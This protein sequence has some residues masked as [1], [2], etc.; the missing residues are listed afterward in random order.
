MKKFFVT[1]VVSL[2]LSGC[3][4]NPRGPGLTASLYTWND[5]NTPIA[6]TTTSDIAG[7]AN[8]FYGSALF[9]D[10]LTQQPDLDTRAA[11]P[12]L[13]E[14]CDEGICHYSVLFP[15]WF[16]YRNDKVSGF[17]TINELTTTFYY[18][19]KD[20]PQGEVLYYH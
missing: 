5:R 11:V 4:T 20:R 19:V 13:L 15:S 10:L 1:V 16:V 8:Y 2:L 18:L 3:I 12:Y 9:S 17:A 6:T 7:F 14:I